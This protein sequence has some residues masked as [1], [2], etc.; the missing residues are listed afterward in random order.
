MSRNT[1][2]NWII[3]N[4]ETN[5]YRDVIDLD[6]EDYYYEVE[7]YGDGEY[8]IGQIDEEFLDKFTERT[9]VADKQGT[10]IFYM[11][12][13]KTTKFPVDQRFHRL[14]LTGVDI[15][16]HRNGNGLDNRKKNLRDGSG[17]VNENNQ[18]LRNDNISGT[19]GVS[20][21]E[22]NKRWRSTWKENGK[23]KIINFS[24][25]KYG[26]DEKAKQEA[27]N[28]RKAMNEITGCLNGTRIR[29]VFVED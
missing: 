6:E 1:D 19:N 5:R 27:I 29:I 11:K 3:G 23:R 24:I 2:N 26:S 28:H 15:V 16:D 17:G 21:D 18:A 14:V 10:N 20:F 13:N 8:H 9:W 4:Y 25:K 12:S 7:I 22:T